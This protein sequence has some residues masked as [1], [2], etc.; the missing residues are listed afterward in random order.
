MW[1]IDFNFDAFVV[2]NE[3]AAVLLEHIHEIVRLSLKINDFTAKVIDGEKAIHSFAANKLPITH[4]YIAVVYAEGISEFCTKLSRFIHHDVRIISD[5]IVF[6]EEGDDLMCEIEPR[7]LNFGKHI[8]ERFV[9]ADVGVKYRISNTVLPPWLDNMIFNEFNADYA[10]GNKRYE[11]NLDLKDEELKVYLGTYFPRSYAEMFCIVDN[12]MQNEII[13][14]RLGQNEVNILD[15]GCGIG[16]ELIG[17]MVA[18]SKY[19]PN[20]NISITAVDGNGGALTLLEKIVERFSNRERNHHIKLVT[21]C[22]TFGDERDLY[23]FAAQTDRYHFILCDKVVCELMVKGILS[24]DA[25]GMIARALSPHLHE[26]GLLILLDVTTRDIR[27][28]LFYPQLMNRYINEY[29]RN[30]KAVETLLPLSCAHNE[31]CKDLCFM[32]QSFFVSHSRKANDESKVCYRI[33]CRENFKKT[34]MQGVNVENMSH[35]IHPKKYKKKE[36]GALC[37]QTSRGVNTIDTFNINQ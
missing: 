35:I 34:I 30:E 36:S 37:C 24:S 26:N 6:W 31:K 14:R 1:N 21:S 8:L 29:V 13:R 9:E 11:Y 27:T 16:G 33:L 25:Y 22:V 4:K 7:K 32:Q 2:E 19:I 28:D 15:I 5:S 10:P 23:Q 17:L 12:L 20:V 3:D 18:L